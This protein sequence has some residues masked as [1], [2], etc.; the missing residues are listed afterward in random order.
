M[1]SLIAKLPSVGGGISVDS[2]PLSNLSGLFQRT[3]LVARY[4]G[5]IEIG[6]H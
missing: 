4:G 6:K 1:L 3:I 5:K 2:H